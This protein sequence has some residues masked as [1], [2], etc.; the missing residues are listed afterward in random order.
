MRKRRGAARRSGVAHKS[1]SGA[2]KVI[3]RILHDG[4][5]MLRDRARTQAGHLG[6]FV[7]ERG[8]TLLHE[9]KDRLAQE[10]SAVSRAVRTAAD[11]LHDGDSGATIGNYADS[12][13]DGIAK[14]ARF[15]DNSDLREMG[16]EV[17][18]FA[19]RHPTAVLCGMFLVGLAGGRLV[20][21]G[22]AESA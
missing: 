10:I 20:R 5:D 21:V 11:N 7:R 16:R 18:Q 22:M 4:M 1:A 14:V 12:A 17:E 9:Q 15:I 6:E 19:R 2:G 3:T 8:E 13:A